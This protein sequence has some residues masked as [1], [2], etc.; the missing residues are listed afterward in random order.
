MHDRT[1]DPE[2]MPLRMFK[3]LMSAFTGAILIVAVFAAVGMW[4]SGGRFFEGLMMMIMPAHTTSEPKVDIRSV[5]IHQIQGASELTTAVFA[6]E[7][8]VP[9]TSDRTLAGYVI[10]KTNLL[11]IAYGEV[12]AGVDLSEITADSVTVDE[13]TNTIRVVLPPPKILDS[14]IDVDR[15]DVYDYDRGFLGLGPDMAPELQELAQKE[16]LKRVEEA[17]CAEGVLTK[18][19]ERAEIAVSQLLST[20]G[21]QTVVVDTQPP[22]A[23]ACTVAES[24]GDASDLTI[25]PLPAETDAGGTGEAASVP[26][27]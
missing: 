27:G 17:A 19:N 25:Q 14:K 26:Q 12:R 15:S 10:G 1:Y 9:T 8:V 6:M 23:G 7:A 21:F 4:R 11:Y 20:T 13:A 22:I 3:G 2:P 24:S 18:A 16:A 5:I